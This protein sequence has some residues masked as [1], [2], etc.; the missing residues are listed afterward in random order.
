[1]G[2]EGSS[3]RQKEDDSARMDRRGVS[4]Q[5]D[6]S[7]GSGHSKN[8]LTKLSTESSSSGTDSSDDSQTP[9]KRKDGDNCNRM[10]VC[11]Y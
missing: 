6:N 4:R 2:G 1:M 5:R 10:E 8:K 9:T 11:K 3:A 7:G